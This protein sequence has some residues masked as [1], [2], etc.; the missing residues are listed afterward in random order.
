MSSGKTI[1]H[2]KT[3]DE[4]EH[5]EAYPY[6]LELVSHGDEFPV[7]HDQ[8]WRLERRLISLGSLNSS[9]VT[10]SHP[11]VSRRH[12]RIE[13]DSTGYRLIDEDSKNGVR[14]NQVRIRDAYLE[15]G[16]VINIGG[17]SLRFCLHKHHLSLFPMWTGDS[18]GELYGT[19]TPMRELFAM[20]E[21]VSR[22]ET[23]I[24]I[25]GESGTGKELAARA[26]HERSSRMSKPFVVFDCSSVPNSLVES[27]L[28]GHV[29]GSF[30][31]ALNDRL[32]AFATANGGTLFLDEIGE[33]PLDLQPKLLRALERGEIKR[34]GEDHYQPVDVRVI[35]ATH[36]D[37]KAAVRS[38]LF[39]ADLYYR[40]AVVQVDIPPLRDHADDI[41]GLV[42]RFIRAHSVREDREVGFKTMGLMLRHHWPGNVR[43]L[44]NYVQR[45]IAL[46]APEAIKLD[47]RF[48]LPDEF[49]AQHHASSRPNSHGQGKFTGND[50]E[51]P[52]EEETHPDID[53]DEHI[54]QTE[55]DLV[56]SVKVDINQAFKEAKHELVEQFERRYWWALLNTYDF[57]VSAAARVAG[58]HRK[59]AEYLL[60]KLKIKSAP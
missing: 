55:S 53:T 16:D 58:V 14:I 26:V 33:L 15:D 40:L 34:L 37:L 24:L 1:T 45:A 41:P 20:L 59:S 60:K 54:A 43:E 11:T 49:I 42:E 30:T 48:L 10:L 2:L 51:I 32:G 39:R 5:L 50:D 44:K 19:S 8:S 52:P 21:R 9:D 27:E 12:A 57:N 35:S 47:T 38:E 17:V 13:L 36:R 31:G 23:S 3:L 18:F 46:S 25:H 22:S 28:F 29:K 7:G 56:F 4:V 6:R